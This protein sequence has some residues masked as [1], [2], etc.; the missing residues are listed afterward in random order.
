VSYYPTTPLWNIQRNKNSSLR[1]AGNERWTMCHFI[2]ESC[3]TILSLYHYSG[4]KLTSFSW[5]QQR[6]LHNAQMFPD[7]RNPDKYFQ[8]LKE[9]YIVYQVPRGKILELYRLPFLAI[10]TSVTVYLELQD[11]TL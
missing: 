11:I 5:C 7:A 1:H 8:V 6:C 9:R 2:L 10:S 3:V 4:P